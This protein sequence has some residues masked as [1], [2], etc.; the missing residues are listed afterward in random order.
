MHIFIYH[1]YSYIYIYI[2]NDY[3]MTNRDRIQNKSLCLHNIC[4]RTV[5]SYYVYIIHTCMY[6]L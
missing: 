3:Q 6:Y 1:T 5:Y 4:V 2:I